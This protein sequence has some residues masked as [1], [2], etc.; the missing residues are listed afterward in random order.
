MND[1][2]RRQTTA[3]EQS[4]VP[5]PD[6]S[7]ALPR[8]DQ[9]P[10]RRLGWLWL[11]PLLALAAVITLVLLSVG[12]RGVP[13]TVEFRDGYGLKVGDSVR[14]RGIVVGNVE[15]ARLSPDL[16]GIEVGLRLQRNARDV[17]RQGARF[18]IVRPKVDL[19]GATGLETVIGANY[20]TLIPGSGDTITYFRGLDEAPQL[21]ATNTG[22]LELLLTASGQGNLRPGAPI[23]Y[24][25]VVIGR[26]L[27]V[28]LAKDAGSVLARA[29]IEP[30]Y[31]S[32]VR[33]QTRFWRVSGAHLSAGFTGLS[34]DVESVRGL[35]LGGVTL[36][37]PPD[38]GSPVPQQARFQ[39]YD[40]PQ[41]AWRRWVPF[42]ALDGPLEEVRPQ[43][44][45]TV[46][47]WEERSYLYLYMAMDEQR[48]GRLLPVAGGLL[49]PADLLRAPEDALE[50]SVELRVDGSPQ[51]LEQVLSVTPEIALLPAKGDWQAWPQ[52]RVRVIDTPEDLMIVADP[53]EPAR[54][55]EAH[56]IRVGKDRWVLDAGIPFDPA[57][58]GAAVLTAKDEALVGL[59]LIDGDGA[60]IARLQAVLPKVGEPGGEGE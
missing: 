46:L 20:I 34:L 40:Q 9:R 18:W 8:A 33:R 13:I 22:G 52:Q 47:H 35:L 59:L 26:V 56:R 16:G 36:A 39:L 1:D 25:Q 49:G 32:L 43:S 5:N 45:A 44:L 12:Q 11:L 28:D 48:L 10:V 19:D 23:S 4:P 42:L 55:V 38:A 2:T 30:R 53:N 27:S 60:Y 51:A 50:G 7:T 6:Q 37:T 24:R 57:W 58:H 21:A 54:F 14:Y 31:T 17:A 15:K 3:A 41:A 29:Y